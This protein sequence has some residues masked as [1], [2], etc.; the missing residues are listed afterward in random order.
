MVKGHPS[1]VCTP[2]GD[3]FNCPRG[4]A[5][6]ATAGSG[7][8]LTGL[9]TGLLAQGYP[10]REATLLGVWLHATAGDRAAQSRGQESMLARDIISHLPA[11]FKEIRDIRKGLTL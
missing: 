5:G 2:Q 3:V 4:N 6:M 11:A 10:C 8:V 1:L 7:D 9:V